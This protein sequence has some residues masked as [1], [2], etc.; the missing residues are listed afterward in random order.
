VQW[1][2]QNLDRLPIEK[3]Q[4]LIDGLERVLFG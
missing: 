4:S 1:K 3:R 2:Q